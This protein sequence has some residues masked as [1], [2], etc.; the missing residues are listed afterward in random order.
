M[1]YDAYGR[2][3]REPDYYDPK[4]ASSS[5]GDYTDRGNQSY[6]ES[7]EPRASN[8]VY[9][10]FQREF[11]S[12]RRRESPSVPQSGNTSS[13]DRGGQIPVGPEGVSPEL[14]AAITEKVKREVF[15]QLK[16]SGSVEIPSQGPPMQR[17]P[18]NKSNSTPSPPPTSRK[19][20]TP[21]SP[22]Q[23]TRQTYAQT[24]VPPPMENMRS[25]P[26]SPLEEPLG[27][28]RF[29]DRGPLQPSSPDKPSG[30]RFSDRGAASRPAPGN[31]TYSTMELS[32]IDQKWGR[33]FESDGKPTQRLGQFLRGLANHI[34]ECFPVKN[35][36]VVTPSKMAAYY[37]AHTLE[38]EPHPLLT[39]FRA[40]SNEHI[41]RLYQDIGCEHHLVQEDSHSSPTI[42]ALTPVGFAHWMT[43]NILAYPEEESKRLAKVV[44]SMPIDADGDLVDGKPERLPKQISRHLLP[45]KE[46]RSSRK[47]LDSAIEN[48]LDD[49]GSTSR[50]K[51]SITSPS[52]SRHSS[53]TARPRSGSSATRG[54]S[55]SSQHSYGAT[56]VEIHQTRTSPT[57]AKA[58]PIERERKPYSGAPSNTSETSE[59]GV[60]IERER[61]PYSA[62]PG[63]SKNHIDN[64]NPI[65]SRSA[66]ANSTSS[67]SSA[68]QENLRHVRMDSNAS[69][70]RY[71]PRAGV[72][73]SSSPPFRNFSQSTPDDVNIAS[74]KYGPNPSASQSSFA[75]NPSTFNTSHR[76]SDPSFPPPP[77]GAPPIDIR[78]RERDERQYRRSGAEDEARFAGEFNSPRDAEKWDRYQDA[79]KGEDRF[80]AY[81]RGSVSVDPRDRGAPVEEWYRDKGRGS[82]YDGATRRY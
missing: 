18:S 71:P 50:R 26:G 44:V 20:Y 21:P 65:Q 5:A 1:A 77:S 34:I 66:R 62:Q 36:I 72:R 27:G 45:N 15:E 17:E 54:V 14:I 30:V 8:T 56:P 67:R 79:A 49:L 39:I 13:T 46:D 52:L 4:D 23:T 28:N 31:R 16:Q 70:N 80:P 68:D 10:N 19:V 61:Q 41:S 55:T 35:S 3:L 38:K 33:L 47:L 81:E 22:T 73:R 6:Y 59:E 25:H 24:F 32:T 53:S 11:T 29:A 57:T 60:K 9:Q 63:N 48:F 58:Q 64:L 42:P 43:I 78:R 74:S 7:S 12:P 51:A 76:D 37:A 82:E 75:T 2:P 69:Q 40:Q